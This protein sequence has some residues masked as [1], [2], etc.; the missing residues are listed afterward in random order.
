[1][2]RICFICHGNICR[3]TMAE[4]V[5]KDMVKK[6]NLEGY[7]IESRATS[8]EE[9]GNDTH[10]GTKEILRK[11]NI[12]FNKRKAI[13]LEATDY[14]KYD[15]FIG[16]DSANI[17]NSMKILESGNNTKIFRFLDITDEPRDISDPWY[18]GNFEQTYQEVLKASKALVNK[19]EG[20]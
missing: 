16:M 15:Y 1:M 12:P 6:L 18:T 17:R 4:F 9:I 19:L 10:Y 3:S 11:Y 8:Y 7:T 5:L 2:K 14:S 20:I 13:H